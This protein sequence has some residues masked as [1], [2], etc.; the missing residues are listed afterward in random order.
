M[1]EEN[2]NK[3]TSFAVVVI[4]EFDDS[5]KWNGNVGCHIE[6]SINN[7]LSEDEIS[8]IRSVCG[9]LA[10]SLVLMEGDE[11]FLDYVKEAFVAMNE[12]YAQAFLDAIEDDDA[13]NYTKEG[14]V[15]KLDFS[16]KTHG[17]A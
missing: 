1:S 2:E 6:E 7:D 9:M 14:N 15:F 12:E 16:S 4:P 13:V 5:G 3:E 11:D 17:S 8:Q 10:T